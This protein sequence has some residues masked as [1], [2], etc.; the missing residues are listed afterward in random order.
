MD[1]KRQG[2]PHEVSP[3]RG[4]ERESRSGS[5]RIL[6]ADDHAI[7]RH[8]LRKTL[9]HV[10]GLEV[11]G[12]AGD[13]LELLTLVNRL[14]PQMVILDISMP[15]LRGIEAV[16]EIKKAQPYT[17]V[18]ILTMH[19]EREYLYHGI[20]AGAEGYLLKEDSAAELFSAIERVRK[21]K[22]YVSPSLSEGLTEDWVKLSRGERKGSLEI[23]ELS[24]RE[25]EVLKLIAEGKSSKEVGGLLFISPRTVERHRA[26]IL[27][28]L[29]LKKAADL[30]KYAVQK[31]YV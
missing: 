9:E 12:E 2:R 27:D 5:Y 8:G 11:I 6:L 14:R 31:G 21:G 10:G 7:L 23:E 25:R 28:K 20:S 22:I 13:G 24:T 18:L 29:N 3:P 30:I 17:K 15:K 16:R 1:R 19:K 26:N 4:K